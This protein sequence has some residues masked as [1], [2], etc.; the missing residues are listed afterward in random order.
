MKKVR[1]VEGSFVKIDLG[2]GRLCFGRVLRDPLMAFYDICNAIVPSL[3]EMTKSPI[4]FR[5]WVRKGAIANGVWPVIGTLPIEG[6][7]LGPPLFF[8]QDTISGVLTIYTGDGR[9][10]HASIDDCRHLERAAV[11]D[12]AHIT[13]RLRD[14]FD[15]RVNKWVE[16]SLR[17]LVDRSEAPP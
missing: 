7:L 2:D 10:I 3:Q 11:W 5:V 14:H 1:W 17:R 15:G 9:E 16:S 4:L 6:H 12:P 8:K 13:D